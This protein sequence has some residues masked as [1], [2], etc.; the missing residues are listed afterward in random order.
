MIVRQYTLDVMQIERQPVAMDSQH[1]SIRCAPEVLNHGKVVT[2]RTVTDP[3]GTHSEAVFPSEADTARH[4]RRD[5]RH[6]CRSTEMARLPRSS[7]QAKTAS[8]T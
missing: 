7:W 5:G 4:Y 8:K 3:V 6:T 1:G 2:T